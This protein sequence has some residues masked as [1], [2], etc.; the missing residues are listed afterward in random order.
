[1]FRRFL[2]LAADT[3]SFWIIF[4]LIFALRWHGLPFWSQFFMFL[5]VFFLCLFT[6]Y[7][8]GLYEAKKSDWLFPSLTALGL[9]FIGSIALFH[10][11][12]PPSHPRVV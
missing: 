11:T 12:H 10:D 6:F 8:F 1:M 5:I 3:L 9:N 4:F 2:N 7:A